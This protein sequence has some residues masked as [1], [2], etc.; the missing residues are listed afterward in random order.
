M[1]SLDTSIIRGLI[2][3]MD[4]VIWRGPEP[5]GDLPAIFSLIKR[6]GWKV[7]LAS[8]NATRSAGQFIEI[9]AGFGV[10]LEPWQVVNSA[11]AT[12]SYLLERY[13]DGGPVY[14]IGQDGLHHEL[15]SAGFYLDETKP[16]A[17]IS[18]M[19]R[20]VTYNKLRVATL[21]IRKGIPF[22]STNSDATFPD[23]EGL[24]PG[25]GS[26]MVALQAATDV[27]PVII[28]KPQPELYRIALSRM[29]ISPEEGL[30]VGDRLETDIAGAQRIDCPTA[31]VLSGVTSREDARDWTPPPDIIADDLGS[32]LAEL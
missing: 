11:V 19:D 21:L 32:L 1:S 14:F 18:S 4:G 5:I 17:V 29:G 28:G 23:P 25:A 22:I 31:L 3:D 12:A 30:M 9:L 20:E 6:K 2:L 24:V 26:I 15:T 16:L 10:K 13:P 8:N 7:V 27:Q